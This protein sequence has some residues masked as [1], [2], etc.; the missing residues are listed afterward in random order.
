MIVSFGQSENERIEIDVHG[1]ERAPVGEYWDDN[2]L[3]VE[4]RIRVGGFCGKAQ[5]SIITS[6]LTKFASELGPLFET[7]A[8]TAEFTTMEGQLKLQLIGDGKGHIE[9]RGEVAD[10][11]GIGNRL[12][13]G[14]QFD[15]SQLGR[16]M[17][18]LQRVTSQ[19]PVRGTPQGKTEGD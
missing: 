11:A 5:A 18:E 4:I 9:L 14:L 15:Q 6:E 19:F 8:G 12:H 16:S 17:S 3:I 1:Y 13:F 2:W 7:L 10:Q